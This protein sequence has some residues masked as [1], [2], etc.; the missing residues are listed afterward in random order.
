MIFHYGT[1]ADNRL[2]L[3]HLKRQ[4][5]NNPRFT[6]LDIGASANPWTEEVVDVTFDLHPPATFT[7]NLNNVWD[8]AKLIAHVSRQGKFSFA[9]CSHTLEDLAYPPVVLDTLPK[10]SEEGYLSM[11]SHYRELTRNIEG[12]WRGYIHHRWMFMEE[13]KHLL[14]IP[15]IPF[16]EHLEVPEPQNE[17]ESELQIHW[18]GKIAYK[19]FNGDYLGPNVETVKQL[20][21]EALC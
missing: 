18:K 9:V 2:V 7:G 20:Y 6:V 15:K 12:P 13:A 17:Q 16:L 5:S 11:P 21:R 8:W 1:S 19:M 14:V 4:K 10:V 3:D